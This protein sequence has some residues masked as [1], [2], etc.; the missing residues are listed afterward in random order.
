M[1]LASASGMASVFMSCRILA[2]IVNTNF[3]LISLHCF[4]SRGTSSGRPSI[5]GQ[6]LLDDGLSCYK[7]NGWPFGC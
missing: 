1:F 2:W 3:G 4:A 7:K 6:A 5:L